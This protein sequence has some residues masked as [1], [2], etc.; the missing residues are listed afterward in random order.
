MSPAKLALWVAAIIGLINAT[1]VGVVVYELTEQSLPAAAIGVLVVLV[2]EGVL[3]KV[4]GAK[5]AAKINQAMA[6]PPAAGSDTPR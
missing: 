6:S 5:V 3:V 4:M 1:F 2:A